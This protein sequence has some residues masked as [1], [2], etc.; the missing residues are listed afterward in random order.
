MRQFGISYTAA[1]N[2][3][4]NGLNRSIPIESLRLASSQV[5]EVSEW[6]AREAYTLYYHPLGRIKPTRAGRFSAV[7]VRAAQEGHI[8]WDSA[9][10]MVE[11]NEDDL[12]NAKDAICE[13][14]PAVWT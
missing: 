5:P 7:V 13:L 11:S 1:R 8:S 6:E 3:I 4:W 2:Q 10:E 14:F 9:A 12:R